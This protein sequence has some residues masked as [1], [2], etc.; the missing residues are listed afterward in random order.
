MGCILDVQLIL[1]SVK[2]IVSVAKLL[3]RLISESILYQVEQIEK[4]GF[5]QLLGA[6]GNNTAVQPIKEILLI[7]NCPTCI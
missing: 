7:V 2:H 3:N 4:P 6:L 5:F 1:N